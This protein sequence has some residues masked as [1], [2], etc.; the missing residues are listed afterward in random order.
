MVLPR[1]PAAPAKSLAWVGA[2]ITA[3]VAGPAVSGAARRPGSLPRAGSAG[4]RTA[5]SVRDKNECPSGRCRAISAC[6]GRS[7][8]S[9]RC[10]TGIPQRLRT[11]RRFRAAQVL[12]C[13]PPRRVQILRF[14][15]GTALDARRAG[16]RCGPA[17]LVIPA[18]RPS[19]CVIL[20][21]RRTSA[22]LGCR[23]TISTP[24]RQAGECGCLA[25]CRR[26]HRHGQA[27]WPGPHRG[28]AGRGEGPHARGARV[29]FSAGG[30]GSAPLF[31]SLLGQPPISGAPA[32]TPGSWPGRAG[33]GVRHR[34]IRGRA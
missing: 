12:A 17:C 19:L 18:R 25:F 34:L 21:P 14:W 1:S 20:A 10:A 13:F 9:S 22:G 6:G 28:P 7:Q 16:R 33:L 31:S 27:P 2:T 11:E 15:S 23:G 3:G 32:S 24:P 30:Y 8:R 29:E 26:D 4:S 5:G